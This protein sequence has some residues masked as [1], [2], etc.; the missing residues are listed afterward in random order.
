MRARRHA[1]TNIFLVC[2]VIYAGAMSDRST[3]SMYSMALRRLML[4]VTTG[5]ADASRYSLAGAL[6]HNFKDI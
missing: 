6:A 2:C 5:W 1:G 3:C 4:G